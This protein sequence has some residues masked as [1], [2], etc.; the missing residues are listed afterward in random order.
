MFLRVKLIT[1]CQLGKMSEASIKPSRDGVMGWIDSL[2]SFSYI[3]PCREDLLT[4]TL[5]CNNKCVWF[6][7]I[8]FRSYSL[9]HNGA[10]TFEL[11]S[12][13]RV[14]QLS[15]VLCCHVVAK[16]S[17]LVVPSGCVQNLSVHLILNFYQ[18]RC[19][20]GEHLA[21]IRWLQFS[22]LT[23]IHTCKLQIAGSSF[24]LEL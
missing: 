23:K 12:Q 5:I 7:L 16:S 1:W 17:Y 6:F 22:T 24:C 10:Q 18:S 4:G 11:D 2:L 21:T 13:E 3:Y 14:C 19:Y 15:I 9:E 8:W 20:N